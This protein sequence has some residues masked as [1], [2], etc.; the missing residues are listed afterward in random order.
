MW[1]PNCIFWFLGLQRKYLCLYQDNLSTRHFKIKWIFSLTSSLLKSI[2]TRS[3]YFLNWFIGERKPPTKSTMFPI[4]I[5]VPC[6]EQAW[7]QIPYHANAGLKLMHNVAREWIRC[8]M[9]WMFVRRDRIVVNHYTP[10]WEQ[11]K[12]LWREVSCVV[13]QLRPTEWL[14]GRAHFGMRPLL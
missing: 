14:H 9:L 11:E 5:S 2:W 6:H 13:L 4:C 1:P 10:G 12:W 8:R 3:N 7:S